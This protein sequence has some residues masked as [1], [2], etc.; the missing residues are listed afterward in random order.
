MPS[1]KRWMISPS[2]DSGSASDQMRSCLV[3]AQHAGDDDDALQV[4]LHEIGAALGAP[5]LEGELRHFEVGQCGFQLMQAPNPRN[6]GDRLDIE[7]QR[8][9]HFLAHCPEAFCTYQ[10]DCALSTQ[11]WPKVLRTSASHSG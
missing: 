2:F 6:V 8:G 4:Q 9:R 7:D 11:R 10:P 1:K 3:V 5:L